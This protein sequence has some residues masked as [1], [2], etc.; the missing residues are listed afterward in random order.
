MILAAV[1]RLWILEFLDCFLAACYD[2]RQVPYARALLFLLAFFVIWTVLLACFWQR[3]PK[4]N[5]T[6]F[7]HPWL[8]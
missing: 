6:G 5:L 4:W 2:A 1:A 7:H 8:A 3:I